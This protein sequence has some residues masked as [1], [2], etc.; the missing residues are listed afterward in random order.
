M[1]WKHKEKSKNV[2]KLLSQIPSLI[3]DKKMFLMSNTQTELIMLIHQ[4]VVSSGLKS[5]TGG[6]VIIA[7]DTCLPTRSY[8][9]QH[10]KE[11]Q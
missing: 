11:R 8:K 2:L 1:L 6:F 7:E 9:G 5:E 3:K 4:W 10:L